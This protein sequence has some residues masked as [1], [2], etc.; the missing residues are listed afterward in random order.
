MAK[1]HTLAV[2]GVADTVV[3]QIPIHAVRTAVSRMATVTTL[4]VLET[5][6]GVVEIFFSFIYILTLQL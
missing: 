1:E 4:P 3:H 2:L 5:V 6:G